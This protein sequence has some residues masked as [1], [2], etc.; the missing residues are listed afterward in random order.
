M[1]EHQRRFGCRDFL[2][3]RSGG[4][5]PAAVVVGLDDKLFA[6]EAAGP[7]DCFSRGAGAGRNLARTFRLT[8]CGGARDGDRDIGLGR[9]RC[10]RDEASRNDT[11]NEDQSTLWVPSQNGSSSVALHPQMLKVPVRSAVNFSGSN[12]VPLW[13]PSQNG[14]DF[15]RPHRQYQYSWPSVR[16]T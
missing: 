2:G 16:S 14:W 13:E 1:S 8:P 7:V 4:G 5:A 12:V 3:G 10:P 6:V 9:R 15:E 11:R